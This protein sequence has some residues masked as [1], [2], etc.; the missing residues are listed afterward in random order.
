MAMIEFSISAR[1]RECDND[2]LSSSHASRRRAILDLE[3][4]NPEVNAKF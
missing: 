2:V 4:R 3:I 1:R